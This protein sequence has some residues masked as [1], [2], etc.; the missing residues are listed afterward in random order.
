MA[1]RIMTPLQQHIQNWAPCQRCEL[2][3]QRWGKSKIVLGKGDIPADVL[4]TGES[5]GE[6]E[7]LDGIPFTGPAG[8]LLDRITAQAFVG[9]EH[10]TRAYT[11]LVA[12]FPREAK[13]TGDHRPPD[14]CIKA[15]APRLKEFVRIVQPKLIILV[16][17]LSKKW[18][19]GQATF[20]NRSDGELEWLDLGR[21]L[22]FCE[23]IHPSYIL[24]RM[25]PAQKPLAVRR[26]VVDI[27]EAISRI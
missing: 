23:I 20:S 13:E 5:P 22:E 16:G 4:F 21:S 6:S 11:N 14:L 2:A 19:P 26:C 25:E 18:I 24:A 15:C 10:L 7:D 12:C 1:F 27:A 9:N 8:A 17:Q 3:S